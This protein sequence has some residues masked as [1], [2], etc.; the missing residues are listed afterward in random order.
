MSI[1]DS[2]TMSE[3]EI[4]ANLKN[5]KMQ[6]YYE[7]Q[8]KLNQIENLS[9]ILEALTR[10]VIEQELEELDRNLLKIILKDEY[11]EE[12]A[13]LLLNEHFEEHAVCIGATMPEYIKVFPDELRR[14][15]EYRCRL[16]GILNSISSK[17]NN[18]SESLKFLSQEEKQELKSRIRM[19]LKETNEAKLDR[20]LKALK[21]SIE[22]YVNKK[23]EYI[24]KQEKRI[25]GVIEPTIEAVKSKK[26]DE[27]KPLYDN[28]NT[29]L[30]SP[31]ESI[32][33]YKLLLEI[34]NMK[35]IDCYRDLVY[36]LSSDEIQIFDME[37][38]INITSIINDEFDE[39]FYNTKKKHSTIDNRK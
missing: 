19:F 6:T 10:K 21:D 9:Q 25:E 14:P 18:N 13:K 26:T 29:G 3:V 17:G 5:E 38:I 12:H 39:Y 8:Q 7:I 4:L 28:I 11:I 34:E 36:I 31:L 30:I 35:N 16:Q 1:L 33:I 24:L 27:L 15:I 22:D 32:F 37:T 2:N 20:Y 23:R